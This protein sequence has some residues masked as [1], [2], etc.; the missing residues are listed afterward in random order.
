MFLPNTSIE[1]NSYV[2]EI[3]SKDYRTARVLEKYGIEYCCGGNWPLD[4]VCENKGLDTSSVLEELRNESRT[5]TLPNS[6]VFSEWKTDFL[7]DYI[8]NVHHSFL[9]KTIPSLEETLA[10]FTDEHKSEY[11]NLPAVSDGFG[12]LARE[13]L[14]HLEEEE[15]IIFPYVRQVAHAFEDKDS[16]AVLLVKTLR[17]PLI[18]FIH[19]EHTI[20]SRQI[21][22][23]RSLTNNYEP[24]ENAC[25]QH[26]VVFS[27]LKEI[28]NDLAQHVYLENEVLFPRIIEMEMELLK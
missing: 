9:K 18:E 4:L 19:K 14:S 28:D 25:I 2:K 22:K 12:Q 15:Q 7:I 5:V 10:E 16:I 21:M 26:K 8:I 17:K 6:V 11:P 24:P 23:M 3:V 27:F 1:G 20:T 13:L